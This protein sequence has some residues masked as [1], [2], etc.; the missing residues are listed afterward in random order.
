MFYARRP[1]GMLG[2]PGRIEG[3]W[4]GESATLTHT[5]DEYS[6][7]LL[8][9]GVRTDF[10]P[11]E[12]IGPV[13][14]G[15][16]MPGKLFVIPDLAELLYKEAV[17]QAELSVTHCLRV[18]QSAEELLGG[19]EPEILANTYILGSSA[20]D[21]AVRAA[22]ASIV[23]GVAT[24]EAQTNAW[25]AEHGGWDEELQD[26]M[27]LIDKIKFLSRRGSVALLPGQRPLQDLKKVVDRRNELIHSKPME[28]A[29][30]F[31]APW[32]P[33]RML[34][35]EARFS[36]LTIRKVLIALAASLSM[37]APGYLS[38]CPPGDFRDEAS[39]A[40][41]TVL[42]GIRDDPD[43]PP[44]RFEDGPDSDDVDNTSQKT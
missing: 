4:E 32:R 28:Q 35:E 17:W 41:A 13:V 43:F 40:K 42:T 9:R 27:G 29:M 11:G 12:V 20:L 14:E 30:D 38:Y 6:W 16:F 1:P 25:V 7:S 36:C 34:S 2:R 5:A 39:W 18:T 44:L 21:R 24:T 31:D 33:G 23:L 3:E 10:G 37:P 8:Q 19:T 22:I 15:R 26:K